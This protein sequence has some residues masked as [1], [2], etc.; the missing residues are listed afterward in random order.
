MHDHLLLLCFLGGAFNNCKE[1]IY[2][3][4]NN[5]QDR[6]QNVENPLEKHQ[7]SINICIQYSFDCLNATLQSIIIQLRLFEIPF[8][9]TLAEMALN[10]KLFDS[11]QV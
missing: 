7:R 10:L 4:I 6:L 1:P 11:F 5:I 2:E 8:T 9:S 3:F